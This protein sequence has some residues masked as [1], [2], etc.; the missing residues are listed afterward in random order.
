MGIVDLYK[1]FFMRTIFTVIIIFSCSIIGFSQIIKNPLDHSVYDSWKAVTN[2]IISDD[3]KWV[4]Y[5]INPQKGDGWLYLWNATTN[6]L[7]SFPRGFKAVLSPLSDFIIYRIKT[8]EAIIRK[9]KK[10]KKKKEDM[11]KDSLGIYFIQKDTVLKYERIKSFSVPKEN[12]MWLAVYLEKEIRKA[13]KDTASVN[14]TLKKN[15]KKTETKTKKPKEKKEPGT[16]LIL[17]N[18]ANLDTLSF[19]RITE[20]A[21][22][23]KGQ[24]ISFVQTN[25][26]TVDTAKV[27][28]FNTQKK[29]DFLIYNS[30]GIVKNISCSEIGDAVAFLATKDTCENKTFAL[31]L[32]TEKT[33]K[34]DVICDTNSV[35]IPKGWT[36]SEFATQ[37]FS[38]DGTKLYFGTAKRPVNLPKDTL[39]DDER[40]SVDIWNWN[41]G[42]LQS[43]QL[44]DLEKDK[45]KNFTAVFQLE[46][47]NI[48][49]LADTV[50]DQVS[51]PFKGNGNYVLA[52][53]N[54]D[55]EKSESW[56]FPSYHDYSII[57]L[58]TGQRKEIVKKIKYNVFLS[59]YEKYLYWFD[60]KD[61][62]WYVKPVNSDKSFCLTKELKVP[63]YNEFE[64]QP[65]PPAAWGNAGWTNNDEFFLVFDRYDIWRFDPTGKN[66]PVKLTNG[67]DNKMSY[68]YQKV[69]PEKNYID[70]NEPLFLHAFNEVNKGEGYCYLNLKKNIIQPLIDKQANVSYSVKAKNSR[71]LLWTENTYNIYPDIH[72]SKEN[73]KNPIVISN[74]N[75]QQ[76]QYL[77]G[78]AELV[79]WKA[80]DGK[81]LEGLL[82]K[83]ENFDPSKK[84]PMISYFYERN[85]NELYRHTTPR[86]SR[87]VI[88]FTYYTSN[89]YLIFVPDVKYGIGHPGKDAYNCIISGIK[90]ICKNSWV[91]SKHIGLQGQ[92]WGG[93][94][95]AYLVT[96]TDSMFAA[97]MAGAPVSNMTSAYGGIRWESGQSRMSQYEDGQS[98]IGVTLWDSL[99]LYIENSPLFAAPNVKTPLLIMSN[100][101]DGAVPWHQGIEYFTALRRLGK[102]V[103]LLN[104]NGDEHNLSKRPNMVDLTI[105]MQQFFDHFLKNAPAP[106][107]IEKGVPALK[108]GVE[109]GYKLT[110]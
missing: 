56:D 9:A 74:A 30:P 102:P 21:I 43:V 44:K 61:S 37:W 26:D 29:Q 88:N 50:F 45:K 107:W 79:K 24:I 103:W 75:P 8:P 85:S 19:P 83:P 6:K 59:P 31:H 20:Y 55:Y 82:Y 32:W 108:K 14:D 69:D 92:S 3:G 12:P 18:T 17:L 57:N 80:Y 99:G 67:R 77:W 98:R 73:F 10:D 46:N 70:K 27:F 76:N 22:A 84:Y 95:I 5:E 110:N 109:K 51:L 101:G 13:K 94:Q 68:R 106:N 100:D 90:E 78:S 2:E 91:D 52:S 40:Y 23:K 97:A 25:K 58:E 54:T 60:Y 63:F 41:D 7:D 35:N 42:Q 36:P 28:V 16:R 64:N 4:S 62:A 1:N 89:G 87:S 38:S 49:Q 53:S 96:K 47:H 72:Y 71:A 93:Y 81:E 48:I 105:R 104:Y 65:T 34:S 15:E 66:I 11:P 33:K 86:P 39:L